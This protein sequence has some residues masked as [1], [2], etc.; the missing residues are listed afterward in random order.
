LVL[1]HER[2]RVKATART[3]EVD[4]VHAWT[5]RAGMV[6]AF[7]EYTDTATIEEALRVA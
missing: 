6:V 2:M 1:G 7:R 5:L 4:W 3:Y